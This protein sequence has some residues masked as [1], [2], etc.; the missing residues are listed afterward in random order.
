MAHEIYPLDSQKPNCLDNNALF[1]ARGTT[2]VWHFVHLAET[3]KFNAIQY[4]RKT[5]DDKV[6]NDFFNKNESMWR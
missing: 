3:R 5:G 4:E 6:D 1:K 2:E